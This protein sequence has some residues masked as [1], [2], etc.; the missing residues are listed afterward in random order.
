[1]AESAP[2]C[3]ANTH[4]G[5]DMAK[6]SRTVANNNL[7]IV[8]FIQDLHVAGRSGFMGKIRQMLLRIVHCHLLVRK[9]PQGPSSLTQIR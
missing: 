3:S 8:L 6:R 9:V 1:M 7:V 4:D 2:N 5:T